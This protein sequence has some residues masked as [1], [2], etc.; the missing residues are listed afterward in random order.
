[1]DVLLRRYIKVINELEDRI[2]NWK[3]ENFIHLKKPVPKRQTDTNEIKKSKIGSVNCA[4]YG[5]SK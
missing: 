2:D 3:R 5:M 4:F 1:M